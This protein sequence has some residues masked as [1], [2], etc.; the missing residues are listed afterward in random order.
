MGYNGRKRKMKKLLLVIVIIIGFLTNSNAQ[1]ARVQ[2][3]GDNGNYVI[4]SVSNDSQTSSS[5][6]FYNN[7]TK[8]VRVCVSV[9]NDQ[10]SE[11]GRDCYDVSGKAYGQ[12]ET[13][14]KKRFCESYSSGCEAKSIKI[15]V[16]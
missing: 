5:I 15:T 16:E 13:L 9:L 6:T 8:S 12:V 3:P 2:V 11:V 1:Q 4:A 7:S 14:S 10:Y